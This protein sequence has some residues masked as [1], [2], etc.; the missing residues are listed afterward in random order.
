MGTSSGLSLRSIGGIARLRSSTNCR[1]RIRR[2]RASASSRTS[3]GCAVPR[4]TRTSGKWWPQPCAPRK[5]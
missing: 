4:R 5:R 2:T 1:A 3:P